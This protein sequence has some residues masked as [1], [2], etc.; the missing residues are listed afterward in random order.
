MAESNLRLIIIPFYRHLHTHDPSVFNASQGGGRGATG[1][2]DVLYC[3]P[4][5]PPKL[6]P[7]Y[8]KGKDYRLPSTPQTR[9]LFVF[10]EREENCMQA[11]CERGWA[12]A[13]L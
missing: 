2:S 8:E 7:L 13:R 4:S 1:A 3:V 12:G 6:S 9:N 10:G 11:G 5:P